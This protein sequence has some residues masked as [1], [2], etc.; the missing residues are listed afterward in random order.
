[1]TSL[2]VTG[3]AELVTHDPAHGAGPGGRLG[4]VPDA[5][6]VV[7]S[8]RVAWTGPVAQAPAADDRYDVGG[9]AVVPGLRRLPQ[10]P[11][12]RR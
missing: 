4:L 9:R 5:A 6:V 3:I 8:G 12:L 7:D 10:P 2:L 11:G 1:M